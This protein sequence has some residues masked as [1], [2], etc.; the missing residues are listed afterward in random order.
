[1]VKNITNNVIEKTS[2]NETKNITQ[3]KDEIPDNKTLD[4]FHQ[5]NNNTKNN[6]DGNTIGNHLKNMFI[7][8]IIVGS[9]IILIAI[10]IIA[11]YFLYC[12]KKPKLSKQSSVYSSQ[13]VNAVNPNLTNRNS[14]R[15]SVEFEET[16]DD[17][18]F[19]DT[20]TPLKSF[21]YGKNIIIILLTFP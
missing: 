12:R 6:D 4:D 17:D 1:M 10:I 11:V 18:N 8:I 20:S 3:N 9:T 21:R 5:I 14:M 13:F 15:Y 2:F 16:E 7:I 19:N